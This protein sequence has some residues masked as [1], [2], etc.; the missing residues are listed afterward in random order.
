ME[1]IKRL[2]KE[3]LPLEM[4]ETL[5]RYGIKCEW[6]EVLREINEEIT[7]I[8]EEKSH[9]NSAILKIKA[10]FDTLDKY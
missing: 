1:I 4:L 10:G 3:S 8:S 9:I 5:T 2:E 7:S 6:I